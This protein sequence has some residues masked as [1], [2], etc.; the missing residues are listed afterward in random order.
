MF[1]GSDDKNVNNNV[2]RSSAYADKPAR[3]V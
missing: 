2:T 3:R 1:T